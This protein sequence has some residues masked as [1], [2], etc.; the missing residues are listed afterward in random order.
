[1]AMHQPSLDMQTSCRM[2]SSLWDLLSGVIRLWRPQ[3]CIEWPSFSV[4]YMTLSH[5]HSFFLVFS[6]IHTGWNV[7]LRTLL[8]R[9]SQ[10]WTEFLFVL[11][12]LF[13]VLSTYMYECM[14]WCFYICVW[15]VLW[16]ITKEL[17]PVPFIFLFIA[18]RS[19]QYAT[20]PA[21]KHHVNKTK[22]IIH[23]WLKSTS[24]N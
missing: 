15:D 10:T 3:F 9:C 16:L 6:C 5:K 24:A 19:I 21:D 4:F 22:P 20:W 1:M 12:V 11:S 23:A 7:P 18:M 13:D 17:L 2:D 14:S 8:S